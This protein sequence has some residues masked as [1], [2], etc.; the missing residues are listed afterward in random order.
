[1]PDFAM[2]RGLCRTVGFAAKIAK[3][4]LMHRYWS[5]NLF[6]VLFKQKEK[7]HFMQYRY[8]LPGC[9]DLRIGRKL[10]SRSVT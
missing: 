1:V 6:Q 10:R 8:F 3:I 2:S 9:Q 5:A 7:L 4:I